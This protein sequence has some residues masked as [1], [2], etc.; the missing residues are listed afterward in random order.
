MRTV[1][2]LG[3]SILEPAPAPELVAALARAQAAGDELIVVHGGGKALS[4]LLQRL[5]LPSEFRQGLRVTDGPTLQAAVMAFAGEVNT[6]LVG[7]LNAAR[8]RAVGLTGLDA[9]CVQARAEQPELGAVGTI[10]A[11][12]PSLLEALLSGGYMPVVAPLAADD[13]GGALNVNADL[14][15]AAVAAA[16]DA[17]YLLFTTDV[18][19]VLDAAG[20]LLARV[21]LAELE[22]MTANGAIRDGMLPKA[23]ACRAALTGAMGLRVEI[24]GPEAATLLDHRLAGAPGPGTVVT[25]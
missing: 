16:C 8:V 6:R 14:F 18:A 25:A 7:A 3:G 9:G 11:V 20:Q 15:A 21:S 2:K 12:N 4:S 1:I 5:G 19:G 23:D 24:V 22:A 17:Q 13:A 10:T